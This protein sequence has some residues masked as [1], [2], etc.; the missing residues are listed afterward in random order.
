MDECVGRDVRTVFFAE[1]V[2]RESSVESRYVLRMWDL[3]AA[4]YEWPLYVKHLPKAMRKRDGVA[5]DS[6]WE[7]SNHA[8]INEEETPIIVKM[9][10]KLDAKDEDASDRKR[11]READQDGINN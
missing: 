10:V 3:E 4:P 11:R 9:E 2:D 5:P 6:V 1:T 7:R 8:E